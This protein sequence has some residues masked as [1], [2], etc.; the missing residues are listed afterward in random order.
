MVGP[1]DCAAADGGAEK[2]KSS[3]MLSAR[4]PALIQNP[5][6][7]ISI[8]SF[9]RELPG[10]NSCENKPVRVGMRSMSGMKGWDVSQAGDC[11]AARHG[12]PC[13]SLLQK[14]HRT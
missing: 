1:E 13:T 10:E 6:P 12:F 9:S 2:L 3:M 7:F 11:V 8:Y 14:R 4:E 5:L